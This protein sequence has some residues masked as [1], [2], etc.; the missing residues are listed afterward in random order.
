M[1]WHGWRP[2]QPICPED[3]YAHAGALYW[4]ALNAYL[5]R[6]LGAQLPQIAE[7]WREVLAFEDDLLEHAVP[8]TA[9]GMEETDD[10]LE[11]ADTNEIAR[12]HPGRLLRH[13]QPL[14]ITPLL[15]ASRTCDDTALANLRQ[16][17]AYCIFFS[18]FVHG[19]LHQEQNSE[20]G[21]IRYASMLTGGGMAPENDASI[22]PSAEL[23]SLGLRVSHSLT[24]FDWGFLLKNED[25]DVPAE[26]IQE[27]QA[28]APRFQAAGFDIRTLRS[29]LNS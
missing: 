26:L 4:E 27:V 10:D 2:R 19:W 17:S 28:R 3:I 13:G 22:L 11:W 21:E 25:G 18:T 7:H 16:M 23:Q 8:F 12:A 14:A 9:R 5:D 15:S 24:G 20:F 6:V 1:D 29:R